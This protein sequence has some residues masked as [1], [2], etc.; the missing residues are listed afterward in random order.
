MTKKVNR[1]TG[2]FYDGVRSLRQVKTDARRMPEWSFTPLAQ[3]Y[4]WRGGMSKH[5]YERQRQQRE[6]AYQMKQLTNMMKYPD[7]YNDL[8]EYIE[9]VDREGYVPYPK[10]GKVPDK[11]TKANKDLEQIIA[12]NRPK[13]S[14]TKSYKKS[15]Y[16]TDLDTDL[17][18]QFG[19]D[20]KQLPK[21]AFL[22]SERSR[23]GLQRFGD[24]VT[25]PLSTFVNPLVGYLEE[26]NKKNSLINETRGYGSIRNAD[27]RDAFTGGMS[28]PSYSIEGRDAK[29]SAKRQS[30]IPKT[31]VSKDMLKSSLNALRGFNIFASEVDPN[32]LKR[33]TD[34]QDE[35][36]WHADEGVQFTK[37]STWTLNNLARGTVG[38]AGD[39]MLDPLSYVNYGVAGL[40]SD[41]TRGTGSKVGK[42]TIKPMTKDMA[43]QSLKDAGREVNSKNVQVIMDAVNNKQGLRASRDIA[44]KN[45]F[46][47]TASGKPLF[48]NRVVQEFGDKT[49]APKVNEIIDA[50]TN[51][52]HMFG[53]K[54][55]DPIK[56]GSKVALAK[57]LPEFKFD[58]N[59]RTTVSR[60]LS[61]DFNFTAKEK[62]QIFDAVTNP[63]QITHRKGVLDTTKGKEALAY[64]EDTF[65]KLRRGDIT[66]GDLEKGVRYDAS[67]QI[68]KANRRF[69]SG[70]QIDMFNHR[71]KVTDYADKL[72][73]YNS[74]EE[75]LNRQGKVGLGKKASS[76]IDSKDLGLGGQTSMSNQQLSM[77]SDVNEKLSENVKTVANKFDEKQL[78][79][80]LSMV[81][82]VNKGLPKFE[83]STAG[84]YIEN[85]DRG[86]FSDELKNLDTKKQIEYLNKHVFDG[87]VVHPNTSKYNLDILVD[88]IGKKNT[89]DKDV[90]NY[91]FNA[92][93]RFDGS[94][95]NVDRFLT[96]HFGDKFHLDLA[97]INY[98]AGTP[99]SKKNLDASLKRKDVLKSLRG[100][101]SDSRIN[102]LRQSEKDGYTEDIQEVL[103]NLDTMNYIGNDYIKSDEFFKA[104]EA[105]RW[106]SDKVNSY[107]NPN[108]E[109]WELEGGSP[110]WYNVG[111]QATPSKAKD[112]QLSMFGSSKIGKTNVKASDAVTNFKD[113]FTG[114]NKEVPISNAYYKAVGEKPPAIDLSSP[115]FIKSDY[116][117]RY[118]KTQ[119]LLGEMY[120]D[121]DVHQQIRVKIAEAF[122]GDKVASIDT[123][124]EVAN[125]F[126]E[127]EHLENVFDSA[128][129]EDYIQNMLIKK[130]PLYDRNGNKIPNKIA[131]FSE[132]LLKEF[133]KTS[134]IKQD[135]GRVGNKNFL[136]DNVTPLLTADGRKLI[137]TEGVDIQDIAKDAGI[138]LEN[139]SD[140]FGN[141]S[142]Q[143]ITKSLADI[144]STMKKKYGIDKFINDDI[145]EIY[146]NH[147]SSRNKMMYQDDSVSNIIENFGSKVFEKGKIKP[148]QKNETV[149]MKSNDL[150]KQLGGTDEKTR[151]KVL[152]L[153]GM[154]NVIQNGYVMPMVEVREK[155]IAGITEY[156]G[157]NALHVIDKDVFHT[158]SRAGL[159]Q[160]IKDTGFIMDT[161]D[162]VT[163][164]LKVNTTSAMPGFHVRNK[165]GNLS[166]GYINV[167]SEAIKPQNM[168]QASD[169]LAKKAGTI[170][171]PNGKISYDEVRDAMNAYGLLDS[172]FFQTEFADKVTDKSLSSK[173]NSIV[174]IFD[175]D[176][177]F[178]YKTMSKVGNKVES[179]DRAVNFIAG[180]KSGYSIEE[181]AEMVNKHLFDYGDLSDFERN[182]MR[183]IIPFYTWTRKNIPLQYE[184]LRDMPNYHRNIYKATMAI[185]DQ[186]P[187]SERVDREYINDFAKNWIQMPGEVTN[188]DGVQEPIMFNP[189]LPYGDLDHL[190]GLLNPQEIGR[191][192]SSR[193]NPLMKVPYELATNRQIYFDQPIK[194]E[195]Y[196]N[197]KRQHGLV[198]LSKDFINMSQGKELEEERIDPYLRY[199]HDQVPS[200]KNLGGFFEKEGSDRAMHTLN[201]LG[202]M[203]FMSY[204]TDRIKY[205]KMRDMLEKLRKEEEEAKRRQQR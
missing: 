164:W 140:L 51:P 121:N 135:I 50:I 159:T 108:A 102:F 202:G 88:S 31:G 72:N 38:F 58:A 66:V 87:N 103:T 65:D 172:G 138:L 67:G 22:G 37:P 152:N 193:V 196:D 104:D 41:V 186:I 14:N 147:M 77:F 163:R 47:A 39:V 29:R 142:N 195:D 177:H 62:E 174:N 143:R 180:L 53:P 84:K 69:D 171:L 181:S 12:E 73:K 187:E 148:L 185:G 27:V 112:Q 79:G 91:M 28:D 126:M 24:A 26:G 110:D 78:G 6:Q 129:G 162:K 198:Q 70:T 89:P 32:H 99:Y 43:T 118:I 97:E 2:A 30:D 170:D 106:Q 56:A 146:V 144:N 161:F 82:S 194:A 145:G 125:E 13:K 137:N 203:K 178:Y 179:G 54:V 154:D 115:E 157:N 166:Q 94:H 45:P 96:E 10:A 116:G 205:F 111:K 5:D 17:S 169:V 134:S 160:Q 141:I 98:K 158:A 80:Q 107:I 189:N 124:N 122:Q 33:T 71:D 34:I 86:L 81:S 7:S 200:W 21:K 149:F 93:E 136:R 101:D 59:T 153:F 64:V 48:N 57:N 151:E 76:I 75:F 18:S 197:S 167:G 105:V 16:F 113:G 176:N 25:A 61:K 68:A 127:L 168:K 119:E 36:G 192:L 130:N 52:M 35:I 55:S 184:T 20:L 109:S 23:G 4:T 133:D 165:V 132:D 46:S 123:I 40:T 173:V 8:G 15:G 128:M 175:T 42:R 9:P 19:R 204:D 85:I 190:F 60:N 100:L 156:L 182:V 92:P 90:L 95:V 183:R 199:M 150:F 188:P 139:P 131:K 191:E 74:P 155:D 83:R 201:H 49:I 44:T 114:G 3:D 63:G 1:G 117:K 11:Y 120:D